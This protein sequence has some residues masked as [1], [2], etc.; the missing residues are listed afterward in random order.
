MV[1]MRLGGV[2]SFL[3]CQESKPQRGRSFVGVHRLW[4]IEGT[5]SLYMNECTPW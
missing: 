3:F 5:L 4:K 1:S 2:V